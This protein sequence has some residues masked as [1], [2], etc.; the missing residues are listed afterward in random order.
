M[1]WR[2][3]YLHGF[4]PLAPLKNRITANQYNVVLI[5]DLYL[6]IKLFYPDGNGLFQVVPTPFH[7]SQGFTQ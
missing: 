3:F 5:G 6:E 1:L 2:S 7:S 4:G